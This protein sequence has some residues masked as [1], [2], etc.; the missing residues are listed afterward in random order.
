MFENLYTT[1]MSMD[2]EKLQKRFA[3]I[4]SKNGRLSK[5]FAVG[6]FVII[7]MTIAAV[8]VIIAVN[9]TDDRYVMTDEELDKF[10]R[11]PIGSMMAELDYA[12]ENKVVFHYIE[13]FFVFD[14][15]SNDIKH[16]INL[17][18]LNVA[19]HAEGDQPAV[20]KVKISSDGKYAYLSSLGETAHRFDEYIIDTDTGRVKKGKMPEDVELFADYSDAF[21]DVKEPFGFH[22]NECIITEDK[23]YYLTVEENAIGAMQLVTIHNKPEDM[24]GC[25]QIFGI[26]YL[27]LDNKKLTAVRETLNENEDIMPNSS[28][29]WRADGKKV[30]MAYNKIAEIM[31][32]PYIDAEFRGDYDVRI[33]GI[34]DRLKR[35]KT[36]ERLFVIDNAALVVVIEEDLTR[37][38]RNAV[39]A[40]MEEPEQKSELYKKTK[41]FL[42]NEY[43]RVYDPYYDIQTLTISDWEEN[44]NEATFWYQMQYL[45]YNRD[46]DKAE[47]IQE[48]KKRSQKGY[49]TLYKDYLAMKESNYQFKIVDNGKELLLYSNDA[50]KGVE[51]VPRKIDDYIDHGE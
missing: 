40:V 22:S 23:T 11:Y 29:V 3:K 51:W 30:L 5:L 43:H 6:L 21:K 14:P 2:K 41:A 7:L 18:K 15:Q 8:T 1:K 17:K 44:G 48:A 34:W 20:L 10:C 47:Y 39:V 36:A 42:E 16:K 12:D 46:P 32:L 50:P 25:G 31:N 13:G 45:N 38:A 49:E 26:R 9:V 27:D 19:P 35:E 4:R 33:Y 24:V 37:E 28:Q